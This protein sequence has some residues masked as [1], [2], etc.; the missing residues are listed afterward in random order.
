MK[1]I[2]AI[3]IFSGLLV[4]PGCYTVLLTTENTYEEELQR[5][6]Q[7]GDD[8][9]Y[10]YED[11][12]V[13][14]PMIICRAA[15]DDDYSP[16]YSYYAVPWWYLNPV[17]SQDNTMISDDIRSL[18]DDNGGRP[19]P[20]RLPR[21]DIPSS[22]TNGGGSTSSG[23]TKRNEP[24]KNVTSDGNNSNSGNTSD[25]PKDDKKNLR[26]SDGNRSGDKGRK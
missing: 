3:L 11:D 13:A 2:F 15:Q 5:V 1:Q 22:T 23:S 20:V 9:E 25:K 8:E 6:S 10:Y 26:N 12:G 17:V 18:R 4:L 14:I 16:F 24:K 19:S 21:I 7:Y